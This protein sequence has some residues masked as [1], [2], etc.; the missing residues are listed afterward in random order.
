VIGKSFKNSIHILK[1]C[2][3]LYLVSISTI[4]NGVS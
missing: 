3:L 1:K 4:V 2:D